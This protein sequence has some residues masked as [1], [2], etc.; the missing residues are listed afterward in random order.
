MK[1]PECGTEMVI[2]EL[3]GW[4]WKCFECDYTGREATDE[5]CEY[6][7]REIEELFKKQKDEYEKLICKK[8]KDSGPCVLIVGDEIGTPIVCPYGYDGDLDSEWEE[9]ECPGSSKLSWFDE[10]CLCGKYDGKRQEATQETKKDPKARY[11]D[12]GGVE[13]LDVII[14]KLTPEQYKGWLLGN[15]IKYSCR[16]NH[17]GQFDRDVEKMKFYGTE[18]FDYLEV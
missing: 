10:A 15:I 18:L 11:Y 4:V 7:R 2:D 8:C 6:Q 9:I 17:K 16:A 13:V 1:C 3:F 5:E 12:A 14:A